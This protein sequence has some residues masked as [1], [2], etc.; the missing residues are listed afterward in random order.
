[1]AVTLKYP[2]DVPVAV[3]GNLGGNYQ[4]NKTDALAGTKI[5]RTRLRGSKQFK[6]FQ[7]QLR[8]SPAQYNTL[9]N[10]YETDT[11]F[12]QDTF[13]W[14]YVTPDRAYTLQ[15]IMTDWQE[16]QGTLG[17]WVVS[18]SLHEQG[19]L[20]GGDTSSNTYLDALGIELSGFGFDF[21]NENGVIRG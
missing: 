3:V 8:L 4:Q 10:F 13:L 19:A 11:S 1:M 7:S 2:E 14:R 9:K 5:R 18:F 21:C 12:G 20:V 15:V 16:N 6:S 17:M